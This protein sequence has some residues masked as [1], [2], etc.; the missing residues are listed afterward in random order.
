[1]DSPT[2]DVVMVQWP[3]EHDRLLHL[4]DLDAPH[5]VMVEPD[6]D[7]PDPHPG[8]EDWIRLPASAADVRVRVDGL[9]AR[10]AVAAS[11][12]P[13][14]DA[15]G[16]IRFRGSSASVSPTEAALL[17][18]L[19]Q[20]WGAV[21]G[22]DALQSL[23]PTGDSANALDASM[24]RLRRRVEPVGLS[25]RTVRRRGYVLESAPAA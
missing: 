20:R 15:S 13:V 8:L 19:A 3:A 12:R 23:L 6:A 2:L 14:I 1:M 5:L 18:A 16:L 25:I 7:P 10:A 9:L 11:L 21:V 4:R 24:S 22:R 17:D